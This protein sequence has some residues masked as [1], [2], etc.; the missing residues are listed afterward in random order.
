M[1]FFPSMK[2]DKRGVMGIIL[3]FIILISILAIGFIA[4]ISL[5]IIDFGSEAI[6]PVMEGLGMV[7]DTNVTEAATYSFGFVD[8]I[9]NSAPWILAFAFVGALVFS[10]IFVVGY[11]YNPNPA[12]MGLYFAFIILLV[13]FAI[14]ISNAY[15][16]IYTGTDEIA[17]KLQDQPA[18]S[19]LILY[20]PF[21]FVLIAFI[22][23]IFLFAGKNSQE[24]V[25]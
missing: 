12:F 13:F 7:G 9:I 18:M 4:S 3:F 16:E 19:Y 20:S 6:T 23:G 25:V 14:V 15:E 10:I 11:T 22:T 8:G 21:I 24:N 1:K 17:L 5:G 2:K